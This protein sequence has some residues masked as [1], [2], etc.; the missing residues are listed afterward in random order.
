MWEGE[1]MGTYKGAGQRP[2]KRGVSSG[3]A[4]LERDSEDAT[5]WMI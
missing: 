5:G 1:T 2:V 4:G 3:E